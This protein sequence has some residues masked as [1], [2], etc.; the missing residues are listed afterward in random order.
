M[1]SPIIDN[2]MLANKLKLNHDK[3][4]SRYH[5]RPPLE[6]VQIGD[7]P[8]TA[9]SSARNLGVIFDQCFN[10]EEHI[11]VMC[12]SLH[13]QIRNIAKIRKYITGESAKIVVHALVISKLDNCNSLLYGLP[14]HLLSRLQSAQNAAARIIKSTTCRKFEHITPVLKEL[15]WLPVHYCIDYKIL[16]LVFKALNGA[17]PSYL[18]NLLHYKTSCCTL[19]SLSQSARL[20][21]YG[22][23]AFEVASPKLWNTLPLDLRLCSTNRHFQETFENLSF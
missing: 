5:A 4:C 14:K 9:T 2:W 16:L 11:R 23:C 15:H 1:T 8:I 3:T 12:K 6:S 17:T 21:S 19:R 18:E 22:D 10:L 20:K 7:L 13:Y